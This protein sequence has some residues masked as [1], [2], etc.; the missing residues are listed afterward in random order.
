MGIVSSAK[1]D[2]DTQGK[3]DPRVSIPD[4]DSFLREA[5]P[6]SFASRIFQRFQSPMGIVSSAKPN[7]VL[8]DP[9]SVWF[10]SPMGI[11]SSAK[12]HTAQRQF[13]W[14]LVSI[15]D[16]DSFLREAPMIACIAQDIIVSIPDG[17]SFLREADADR[18]RTF[19]V[20]EFQSPM[21][22]VSSAKSAILA[23]SVAA[24][25]FQSP[26]GIVSSAKPRHQS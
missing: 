25:P 13:P 16:G 9:G 21:G 4:G 14:P 3:T 24:Q 22:I 15:P 8:I 11:V 5:D 20:G 7:V 2:I 23:P 6:R 17:D 18:I 26:M 10:Q 19:Y 12:M 1:R